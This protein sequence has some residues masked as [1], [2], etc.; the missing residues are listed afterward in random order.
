MEIHSFSVLL[1]SNFLHMILV[2][3]QSSSFLAGGNLSSSA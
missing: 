1:I 3:R 2:E